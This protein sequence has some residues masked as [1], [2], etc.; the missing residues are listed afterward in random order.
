MGRRSCINESWLKPVIQLLEMLR[1]GGCWLYASSREN[2]SYNPHLNP[3]GCSV[4]YLSSKATWEAEM[5]MI[6]AQ[7]SHNLSQ[8]KKAEHGG[9][10]LSSQ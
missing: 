6:I 9:T 10:N 1:L 5:R 4:M 3:D 7:S 8:W 2:S